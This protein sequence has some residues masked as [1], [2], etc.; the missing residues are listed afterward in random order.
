MHNYM[1]ENQI[2]WLKKKMTKDERKD[3]TNTRR[4]WVTAGPEESIISD[5]LKGHSGHLVSCE[6]IKKAFFEEYLTTC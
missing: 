6:P 5:C 3:D 4:K 2:Q 1:A